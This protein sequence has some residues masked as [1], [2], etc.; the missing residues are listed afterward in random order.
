LLAAFFQA[1]VES[2]GNL[3][4]SLNKEDEYE[5]E[6]LRSVLDSCLVIGYSW[7][8]FFLRY[9]GLLA[10]ATIELLAFFSEFSFTNFN[11]LRGRSYLMV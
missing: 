2:L 8:S 11:D 7:R 1:V 3:C 9:V 10:G 6:Y 4:R 5:N